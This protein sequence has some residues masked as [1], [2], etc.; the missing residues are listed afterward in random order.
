MIRCYITDRSKL[1]AIAMQLMR[2]IE[3]I[4]IRERHLTARELQT[5]AIE[6][7]QLPNP[8]GTRIV[9]NDRTDVALATGALG[10]HLRGH[11]VSP[12]TIRAIA[13]AA[14]LVSVS[15]HSVEDVR[16]AADEGADI[17][18]LAPIY[19]TPCKGPPLGLVPLTEAARAVR[20][21]VLAL[22]GITEQRIEECMEA[23]AAGIA[24][25]SMFRGG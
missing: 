5:L 13:P 20:I 7:L 18:L 19:P 23:G 3:W 22:G 24:G 2:G 25:I 8:H 11:S 14:F 9:I 4:Q 1:D 17:A 16:R 6:V 10:V 12:T 15:C 21:P